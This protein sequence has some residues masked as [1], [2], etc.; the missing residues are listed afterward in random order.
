MEPVS[1]FLKAVLL[2]GLP[3]TWGESCG[4]TAG[5]QG[6]EVGFVVEDGER[7][8]VETVQGARS[9]SYGQECVMWLSIPLDVCCVWSTGRLESR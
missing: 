2:G 1:W 4:W 6:R 5:D 8:P 9:I 7:V 3:G